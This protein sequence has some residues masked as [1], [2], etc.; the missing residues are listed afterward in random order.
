[1]TKKKIIN[2]A[3]KPVGSY[4]HSVE[5]NGI[6]YLSGV[7]PRNPIDNT[8]PGNEYNTNGNLV[9]YDIQQ[10]THAVFDNIKIILEE[11]NSFWGNL[12][13]ITV[14]LIDMKSDFKKFN[15]IYNLY[16]PDGHA[17]RTTI[18][19]NA[20]PTNIAIELKCISLINK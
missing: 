15:D 14:F 6:L 20:L 8:I 17:C 12:I 10:Q 2:N 9:G 13:D 5:I 3:P 18:E 19:V 11:S 4:P 7:G 16:F 1:M